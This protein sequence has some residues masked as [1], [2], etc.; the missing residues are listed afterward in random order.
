MA[1]VM[2]GTGGTLVKAGSGTLTLTGAN[3]YTGGTTID[4]GILQAGS[5]TAFGTA[6]GASLTFGAS[7]TGKVQLNGN[8]MTVIGLNSNATPGT[9]I[10]ESG[11]G[12]A[13]TDTLTV[14]NAGTNTYAGVLQNGSTRLLALTKSGAGT[15][16]LSGANTYTG[17]T[18]ITGGTLALT[19]DNAING[20]SALNVYNG[21]TLDMTNASAIVNGAINTNKYTGTGTIII[22]TGK[23]LTLLS[24]NQSRLN[25]GAADASTYTLIITGSGTLN[26]S[27]GSGIPIN[28]AGWGGPGT[29]TLQQEGCTI[30]APNMSIGSTG[31]GIYTIKGGALNLT[32]AIETKDSATAYD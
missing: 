27:A 29:A 2:S 6:T 21:G 5:I 30:T 22:G 31:P 10:V 12:T 4:A 1:S 18:N 8:S 28:Q 14:N 16:T 7:S 15:L 13:G 24:A 11:S 23:T 25:V 26:A 17:V 9:P 32:G 20:S 19:A 3:T